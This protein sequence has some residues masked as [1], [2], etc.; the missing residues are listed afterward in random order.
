MEQIEKLIA[1]IVELELKMFLAVP[2]D[3]TG[4]CQQN[5]G[6]FKLHRKA[7]FCLWS[8]ATLASYLD[9]LRAADSEGENLMTKKYA[10]IQGL[11]P[12]TNSSIHLDEILQLQ[13]HWQEEMLQD[14]PAFK[15][16]TRPLTDEET[17]S[18]LVSF[19]SYATGELETYSEKTLQLLH[20]DLQQHKKNGVNGSLEIYT[21][22]VQL[23]RDQQTTS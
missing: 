9:D 12:K 14:H 8:K 10:I 5:P 17:A 21:R 2:G 23:S 22:L 16:R 7:Q 18:Q 15:G 11:I 20:G 4:N 1:E 3:G 6:A 13:M 19:Q